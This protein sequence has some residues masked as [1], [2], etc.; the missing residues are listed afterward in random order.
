[1]SNLPLEKPFS[2]VRAQ[3]VPESLRLRVREKVAQ[4][5]ELGI[6]AWGRRD[7]LPMPMPTVSFDL[8]GAAAGQAI[9]GLKDGKYFWHVRFNAELLLREPEPIVHDVVPHEIAHLL[10]LYYFKKGCEPH[11]VEWQ[12]VMRSLGVEPT[13]THDMAV[14]PTRVE[15]AAYLYRCACKDHMLT[16]R[17]H[18]KVMARKSDYGCQMCG[19]RLVFIRGP[20]GYQPPSPKPLAVRSPPAR[21]PSSA[22]PSPF[23]R[24]TPSTAPRQQPP[25]RP[26]STPASPPARSP[27]SAPGSAP[28][29]ST[30]APMSGPPTE[31]QL[32][33]ARD[34]ALRF[35]VSIPPA[36]LVDKKSLSNWIAQFVAPRS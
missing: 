34:L 18:N 8:R 16:A 35:K 4:S 33:F 25:A 14:T 11:G 1:M 19:K 29:A 26:S 21:R 22:P 30:P 24:P 10:V 32:T 31:K 7:T 23:A 28:A 3:A 6:A 36:A 27:S 13:R 2:K 12:R 9:R 15:P 20:E 5:V 17:R